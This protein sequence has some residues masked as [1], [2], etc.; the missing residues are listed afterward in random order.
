[1][2]QRFLCGL[3]LSGLLATGPAFAADDDAFVEFRVLKPEVALEL[4]QAAMAH[5]QEAGYQVG[6]SV[7]DRFGQPQVFIRDRYAGMHVFETSRRKA[8]TAVSFRTSTSALD[9]ATA[10]GEISQGIR[11]LSEALALG[12]GLMI[13]GGGTILGGVGVSGAP[14]PELDEDCAEA[15]IAAVEVKIAF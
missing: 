7:V 6:V 8:W 10:P 14:S 2:T 5:C 1:M 9:A 15:G 4:A 13:E 12:G 3:T 11:Q